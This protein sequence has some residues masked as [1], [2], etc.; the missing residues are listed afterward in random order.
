MRSYEFA[1]YTLRLL[2]REKLLFAITAICAV[3]WLL[4]LLADTPV[5]GRSFIEM[6]LQ[7]VV[8]ALG[9]SQRQNDEPADA[10]EV[11]WREYADH[12][13]AALHHPSA[14]GFYQEAKEHY[15]IAMDLH[16][17]GSLVG[18]EAADEALYQFCRVAAQTDQVENIR[19]SSDLPTLHHFTYTMASTP[20]TLWLLPSILVA[21]FISSYTKRHALLQSC[22]LSQAKM[23]LATFI[24]GFSFSLI[25]LAVSY[26][27]SL[28][29]SAVRNGFGSS[30]YPVIFMQGEQI[31]STS[32]GISFV[33]YLCVLIGSNALISVV[34]ALI[35]I[36]T[37]KPFVGPLVA[38]GLS[39]FSQFD[40]FTTPTSSLFLQLLPFP[41]LSASSFFG[42]A[43][44]FPT[45]AVDV[46]MPPLGA[47]SVLLVYIVFA[48]TTG[49]VA[50][51]VSGPKCDDKAEGSPADD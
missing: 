8:H 16:A 15:Q 38:L 33:V 37:K 23:F 21:V 28:F 46:S 9:E 10:D 29:Y 5:F 44:C 30:A 27:P 31:V 12:A 2:L 1:L 35:T 43:S 42:Y 50:L 14:N 24:T 39:L 36:C 20:P 32:V 45:T 4:P 11:L 25:I 51:Y 34:A 17:S 19:T 13:A 47:V 18:A 40:L 41:Y 26:V 49:M 6:N 48:L 3:A 22:P 7:S